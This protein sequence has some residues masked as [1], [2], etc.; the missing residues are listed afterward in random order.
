MEVLRP[1]SMPPLLALREDRTRLLLA[2]GI[3]RVVELTFNAEMSAITAEDFVAEML[4][5]HGGA[6]RLYAGADWRFGRGGA[7]TVATA[8]QVGAPLG[9]EVVVQPSRTWRGAPISSSRIRESLLVGRVAEGRDMLGRLYDVPGTVVHGQGRGS[10]IGFPT[11]NVEV[12]HRLV[13]PEA[14]VYAVRVQVDGAWLPAVANLG[15][16]PT[17]VAGAGPQVLEAHIFDFAR[18]IYE[19]AVRVAFAARLRGEHRFRSVEALKAQIGRDAARARAILT[20]GL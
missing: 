4:C 10:G 13:L 16:R 18:S 8:L 15:T 20:G 6:K 14:G 2:T 7:G 17:F 5:R 12:S 9:L 19:T 3:E 1:G 11:A